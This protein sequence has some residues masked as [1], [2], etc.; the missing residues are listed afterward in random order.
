[1]T[2]QAGKAS[3]SS[4]STVGPGAI[5]VRVWEAL[6]ADARTFG[7]D[8][9]AAQ[10]Q[11]FSELLGGI[12]APY[13]RRDVAYG[14]HERQHCDLHAAAPLAAGAHRPIVLYVHG[15]GFVSGARR[16]P[17]PPFY[18]NV[19]AWAADHGWIG[20]TMSYRLAP[21]YGWPT[22]AEDIGLAVRALHTLAPQIGGDPTRIMLVGHSAGAAHVAGYLA[23][24]G[25]PVDPGIAGA[26]LQSGIYDP[27]SAVDEI[28]EIVALYYG[29]DRPSYIDVLANLRVPVFLGV[30]EYD[31]LVFVRQAELIRP[32]HVAQGHSHFSAV[33]SLGL[34]DTYARDVAA[35]VRDAFNG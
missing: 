1:M 35:F 24:Q 29:T 31:P 8:V 2:D 18:D 3:Q 32:P 22:G 26:V 28:A 21:Q 5:P 12:Q 16:D 27:P 17:V 15:G 23:G 33:Y 6:R 7:M 10:K 25:G 20:V 13:L 34:D 30:G 4:G 19:G 14:D 11:M 9:I